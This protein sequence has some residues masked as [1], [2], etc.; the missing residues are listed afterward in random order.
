M[1]FE[2]IKL[3]HKIKKIW[4]YLKN[5]QK[6]IGDDIHDVYLYIDESGTLAKG[7]DDFFIM[8]CFITDSVETIRVQLEELKK[9]IKESPYFYAQR[10]VFLKQGFHACENHPDIRA[11]Y[12]TLLPKLN[13]RI[14]SIVINKTSHCF[15]DICCKY[16]TNEAIYAYLVKKLLFDRVQGEYKKRIHI[17]F[18]EYGPSIPKH[19]ANMQKIVSGISQKI[20]GRYKYDIV[21]DVE[22][23]K[24]DDIALSVIDYVNYILCQILNKDDNARMMDNFNLI[25]PKIA[26]LHSLHN[27]KFYNRRKRINFAEIKQAGRW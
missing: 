21:F 25:E 12:Y 6:D 14:Y 2:Y 27:D 4:H 1:S 26:L 5:G 9:E 10:K 16:T 23:H 11:K 17:V 24:K 22:V 3:K 19:Q 20:S 15:S 13:V 7:G 18:E 8:S